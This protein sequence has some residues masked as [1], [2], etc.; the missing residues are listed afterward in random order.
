MKKIIII[1]ILF[2]C[3]DVYSSDNNGILKVSS[4]LADTGG[5]FEKINVEGRGEIYSK[6]KLIDIVMNIYKSSKI[7]EDYKFSA[8]NN[9]I[10]LSGADLSIRITKLPE[11]YSY[12]VYFLLSQHLDNANIN[13]IRNSIIEGFRTYSVKPTLSYLIVGK[14]SYK[15][16]MPV[17]MEKANKILTNIGAKFINEISDGNLVSIVGFSPEIKEKI[18]INEIFTN[19]NIA[20]RYNNFDKN[21]YIWIGCPIISIEY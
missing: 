3:L 12:D 11:E 6:E 16:T 5:I 2:F 1:L 21:T 9:S 14:Y 20:L 4:C 15:M 18:K 17:M 7:K 8:D 10:N 13:S 19:V